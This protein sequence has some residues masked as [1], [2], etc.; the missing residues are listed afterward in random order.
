MV[1]SPL[2]QF[3][4]CVTSLVLASLYT[5]T[6]VSCAVPP[7]SL[8]GTFPLRFTLLRVGGGIVVV[9]VVVV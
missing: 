1:E 6:A 9:V 3:A 5:A 4:S 7:I 8:S 2:V